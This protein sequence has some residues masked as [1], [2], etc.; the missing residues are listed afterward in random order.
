MDPP[1]TAESASGYTDQNW[2]ETFDRIRLNLKVFQGQSIPQVDSPSF[3]KTID[4]TLLKLDAQPAQI[5][6][7]CVEAKKHGFATVCIRPNFVERCTRN[8]QGT[9]VLVASVI[10]F[11]EGTYALDHKLQYKSLPHLPHQCGSNAPKNR[12]TRQSLEGG[13]TEL[14]VVLNRSHL[15]TR[16]YATIFNELATLRR[17][18]PPPVVQ[19]LIFETAHLGDEEIL[20][21]CTLA[22][23]A[24]FDFVKT[25][26]GFDGHGATEEVV[27]LMRACCETLT[28]QNVRL[29][30]MRVKASG[31]IRT[32]ANA[33]AML[34]AGASRLGASSGVQIV[35]QGRENAGEHDGGATELELPSGGPSD[36]HCP[37][38][39]GPDRLNVSMP[40][41][42]SQGLERWLSVRKTINLKVCVLHSMEEIGQLQTPQVIGRCRS[43]IILDTRVTQPCSMSHEPYH[44]DHIFDH[45]PSNSD[46][47]S[48]LALRECSYSSSMAN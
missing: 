2:A 10:G 6:Q 34:Q 26:T 22:A 8:L 20:A 38:Y 12:E 36:G 7:L 35:E 23:A 24:G 17:Q 5:D 31:G 21:A 13:A 11:H 19:K 40:F 1:I 47:G 4:H 43:L 46:F 32:L 45:K 16:E 41:V 9:D 30:Q 15:K 44:R 42:A 3:A 28:S 27:R 25:S 18:A 14:D 29:Q 33:V 39:L 48:S 37:V